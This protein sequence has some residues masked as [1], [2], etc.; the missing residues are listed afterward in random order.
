MNLNDFMKNI[1]NIPAN[2]IQNIGNNPEAFVRRMVGD[3]S[4]P[5]V[6]NLIKMAKSGDTN[7][8]NNFAKNICKERGID[9][10]DFTKEFNAFMR[11]FNKR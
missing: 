4:N 9:F 7:G 3:N 6:D 11:P 8:I 5:M 2:L 1:G 10:D